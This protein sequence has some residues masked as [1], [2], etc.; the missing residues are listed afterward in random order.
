MPKE[1][2]ATPAEGLAAAAARAGL[3]KTGLALFGE[4]PHCA[5]QFLLR[6]SARK[7]RVAIL[8]VD[9]GMAD[10]VVGDL[11]LAVGEKLSRRFL[12]EECH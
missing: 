2:G 8:A 10:I 5:P 1:F 7:P 9:I 4:T 11:L 12:S 6:A 3:S